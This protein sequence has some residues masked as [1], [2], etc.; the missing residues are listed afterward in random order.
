MSRKCPCS[1]LRCSNNLLREEKDDEQSSHRK[2]R[3][4]S[5]EDGVDSNRSETADEVFTSC[6]FGPSAFISGVVVILRT[7]TRPEIDL[8]DT[9]IHK[10]C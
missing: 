7:F 6:V 8:N 4:G 1:S 2:I 9:N 3:E 10:S 5:V